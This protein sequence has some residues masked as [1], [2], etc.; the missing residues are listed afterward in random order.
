MKIN[1]L[2]IDEELQL[3]FEPMPGKVAVEIDTKPDERITKAGLILPSI[4]EQPSTQGRVIAIFEEA[5][6]EGHEMVP[7]VK[8]GDI[9]LFG[10]YTG[11]EIRVGRDRRIIILR[12]VDILTKVTTKS[13]VVPELEVGVDINPNIE[14]TDFHD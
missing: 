7:F 6:I 8:I 3:V 14:V 10:K 2:E 11:T 4:R 1:S 12:E 13:A 9:V 5:E